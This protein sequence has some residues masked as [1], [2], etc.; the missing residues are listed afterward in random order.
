MKKQSRNLPKVRTSKPSKERTGIDRLYKYTGA[1]KV[2]Y[3]YQYPDGSSETL[4]SAELGNRT[5]LA[6]AERTAKRKAL[7]IQEGKVIVGSVADMIDRFELEISPTHYRDQ[8]KDGLAVRKS[9]YNN[10]KRFSV[11][12]CLQR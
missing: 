7:D 8:S 5:A 2:S 3:Y 1:R 9:A 12:W 4:A 11:R 10:L 6:D